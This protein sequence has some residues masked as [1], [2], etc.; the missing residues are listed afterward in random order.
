MNGLENLEDRIARLSDQMERMSD[1]LS[2]RIERMSARMEAS[3]S[4]SAGGCHWGTAEEEPIWD[5]PIPSTVDMQETDNFNVPATFNRQ[6]TD[7]WNVPAVAT[8][9]SAIP[10]EKWLTV[11]STLGASIFAD[12]PPINYNVWN[13]LCVYC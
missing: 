6:E 7:N 2:V 13:E 3:A 1:R 4:I 10:L 8:N 11:W 9:G 12:E 5:I